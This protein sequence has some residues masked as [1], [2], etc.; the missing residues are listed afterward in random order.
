M[1]RRVQRPLC[2]RGSRRCDRNL[3][4]QAAGLADGVCGPVARALPLN[5]SLA[6]ALALS[7]GA[8]ARTRGGAEQN[9]RQTNLQNRSGR[10][11]GR[12][13]SAAGRPARPASSLLR[14]SAPAPQAPS[15]LGRPHNRQDQRSGPA[16]C[17]DT[18]GP[19]PGT[20]HHC[21]HVRADHDDQAA[22]MAPP[23]TPGSWPPSAAETGACK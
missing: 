13:C 15:Q 2:H 14:T 21:G 1:P 6:R 7:L 10:G 23:V 20:R 9:L 12:G 18:G 3:C 19:Q 17:E 5:L 8:C 22:H 11:N 16:V 4:Q